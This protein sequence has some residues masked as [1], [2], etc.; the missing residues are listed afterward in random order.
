MN[1][2]RTVRCLCSVFSVRIIWML[3]RSH[4]I[5]HGVFCR[6][7]MRSAMIYPESFAQPPRW[8]D[9]GS[10]AI[11]AEVRLSLTNMERCCCMRA[12]HCLWR[13]C[14]ASSAELYDVSWCIHVCSCKSVMHEQRGSCGVQF[15]MPNAEQTTRNMKIFSA[16]RM[17]P[18]WYTRW[19]SV[20]F[21]S[22][23]TPRPPGSLKPAKKINF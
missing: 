9:L 19:F 7:Y 5:S 18:R 10:G 22:R 3:V 21:S 6:V 23:G 8:G 16:G 14:A 1:T 11:H 13:R 17:S 20:H 4:G 2:V 12:L 15:E